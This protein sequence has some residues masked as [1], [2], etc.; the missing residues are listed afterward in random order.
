MQKKIVIIKIISIEFLYTSA[1][2][3]MCV[4][5]C[6]KYNKLLR[7]DKIKYERIEIAMINCNKRYNIYNIYY[8]YNIIAIIDINRY[9]ANIAIIFLI[10]I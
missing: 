6:T 9:N 5:V 7:N 2:T 3:R 4:Y 8:I 10:T 1:R